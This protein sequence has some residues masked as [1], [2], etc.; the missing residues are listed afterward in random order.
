MQTPL[1]KPI[2]DFSSVL[3]ARAASAGLNA[4]QQAYLEHF[5]TQYDQRHRTSKQ[6]AQTYRPVLADP[7]V[8]A[9]F[10][11]LLK[12][13]VYP[14]VGD[15]AAGSRAWDADG[16]E[17]VDFLMGF[18]VHLLGHNSPVVQQALI[19]R[20]Q[21]GMALGLQSGLVGEVATLI[22]DLTG[23]ERVA[24]SNTGT[25]AVMTAIR[26]ARAT[27]KR[28]KIA[29]FAGSYHGHFDGTLIKADPDQ[30]AAGQAIPRFPGVPAAIAQ[31]VL[32]L[33]YDDPRSLEIIKTHAAQLA[34]VLVEPVQRR[35]LNLQPQA[36]LQ[37]LRQLTQDQGIA[38]IFDEMLTGFR[39]H[40][41][42]AQAWFG[43]RADIAIYGKIIGGGMPIGVIAGSAEYLDKIDGGQWQYGDDSAPQ[44]ETTFF[45]GTYCKH[46]LVMTAAKAI[47]QHLQAEGAA[48]Q[49]QLNQRT[50]ALSDRLN[51]YFT[52]VGIPIQ[53]VNFGSLFG[54]VSGDAATET[55]E[56]SAASITM[57]LLSYHLQDQGILLFPDGSGILSTAHTDADSDR[58]LSAVQNSI[59]ALAQGGFLES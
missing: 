56:Q 32:V 26:L 45:A 29:L 40:P 39:I 59:G 12:E 23:M 25:E 15:R 58:L 16:N 11:P 28:Q 43:V 10:D 9:G 35:R 6:F 19:E 37:Q 47:L 53:M 48:L 1:A 46:P 13:M 42:G 54:P 34:A 41:G 24:F 17:Y 30:T 31:D 36:F 33:Q 14:I 3:A 27:T 7:R 22:R 20:L 55:P 50:Q 5:I 57:L 4:R 38:L 51:Q 8:A 21:Q 49:Q 52:Q 44:V 18:G 2:A